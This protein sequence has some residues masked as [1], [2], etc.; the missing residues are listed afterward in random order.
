MLLFIAQ[1]SDLRLIDV[2]LKFQ[3]CQVLV[4]LLQLV[5]CHVKFILSSGKLLLQ[6]LHLA[7]LDSDFTLKTSKFF[8][9]VGKF[10]V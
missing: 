2:D 7:H 8:I 5:L 6:V 3:L 4:H 10:G 9:I 1:A